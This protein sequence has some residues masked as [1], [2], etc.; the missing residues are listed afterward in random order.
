MRDSAL[1]RVIGLVVLIVSGACSQHRMPSPPPIL[2]GA[3]ADDYGGRY[4]I[5]A[6]EWRHG[7]TNR[8]EILEWSSAEHFLI[9]RNA[10]AN[11]TDG[12]RYTRIDWVILPEGGDYKWAYCYSAYRAE[13]PQAARES[14][15][16]DPRTPRTGCNGYPFSRMKPLTSPS[17]RV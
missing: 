16:A 15:V 10:D 17:P 3:F 2:M 9:A 6:S 13:S 1:S 11:S 12:G 14:A 5:S 4:E 8:Y 7:R